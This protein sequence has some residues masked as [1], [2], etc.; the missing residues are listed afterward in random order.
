MDK[1][2]SGRMATYQSIKVIERG[3]GEL[4]DGHGDAYNG[5]EILRGPFAHFVVERGCDDK[6]SDENTKIEKEAASREK[7]GRDPTGNMLCDPPKHHLAK[8]DAVRVG[9]VE[10]ESAAVEFR[11]FF[12]SK[13]L[14]RPF[15]C[16]V[17]CHV[18]GNASST[19]VQMF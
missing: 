3:D 15:A 4:E 16:C 19:K 5:G 8:V 14:A 7:V 6:G 18:L 12:F 1:L 17:V 10:F 11:E 9:E 13:R 2:E